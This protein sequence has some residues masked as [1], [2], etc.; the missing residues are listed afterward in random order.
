MPDLNTHPEIADKRER[1]LQ[2]AHELTDNIKVREVGANKGYWVEK[3]LSSVGLGGGYAWC[4][5]FVT[6]QLKTAG[7]EKSKLPNHPASV[8]GWFTWAKTKGYLTTDPERGDCFFWLDGEHGHIGRFVGWEDD[9]KTTFT[10]LEGN[11]NDAGSRE[12]DGAYRK[13]RNM[14]GMKHH[15]TYGFVSL[16]A[17]K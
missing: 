12:G 9:A 4:A 10:S 5:A 15:A 14:V 16:R 13:V 17:L 8:M 7:V 11:T 3:F 2:I 6:F 1:S